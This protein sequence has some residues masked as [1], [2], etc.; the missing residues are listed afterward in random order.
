MK[1][2][3]KLYNAT[4]QNECPECPECEQDLRDNLD[5]TLEIMSYIFMGIVI[6]SGAIMIVGNIN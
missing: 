4:I 3:Q 5:I 2:T 1:L 6:I